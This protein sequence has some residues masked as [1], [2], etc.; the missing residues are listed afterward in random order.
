M[1]NVLPRADDQLPNLSDGPALSMTELAAQKIKEAMQKEG[2][3]EG[4]LRMSIVGGGCSGFSYSLNLDSGAREDDTVV[5]LDGV[6]LFV[7]P[8][9]QQ[10]VHGTMLD[11]QDGLSGAGFRFVNP[12]AVRTCG[13]GTYF[14][15]D[16]VDAP[17]AVDADSADNG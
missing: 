1:D 9:S 15:V 4:G 13:C 14:A 6:Q 17:G 2:L 16:A 10:Y 12:N 3:S 7:D 8:I 5:E 11:Y